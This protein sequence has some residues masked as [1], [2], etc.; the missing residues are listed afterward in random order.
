MTYGIWVGRLF[1]VHFLCKWYQ[2]KKFNKILASNILQE[3]G[4]KKSPLKNPVST[5]NRVFKLAQNLV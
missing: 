2:F 1:T 5:R 3:L 4:M